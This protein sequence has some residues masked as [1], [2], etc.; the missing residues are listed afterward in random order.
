MINSSQTPLGRERKG[1]KSGILVTFDLYGSCVVAV[2]LSSIWKFTVKS[3]WLDQVRIHT[4]FVFKG[5]VKVYGNFEGC[6]YDK[7]IVFMDRTYVV[8]DQYGYTYSYMPTAIIL[9]DG[10]DFKMCVNDRL[11]RIKLR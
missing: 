7:K 10:Y 2:E 11:Y 6:D 5:V 3:S 9:S 4:Y 1:D 8:C